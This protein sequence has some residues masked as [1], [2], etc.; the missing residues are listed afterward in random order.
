MII[1]I[2]SKLFRKIQEIKHYRV[3]GR[4]KLYPAYTINFR[5]FCFLGFYPMSFLIP[6]FFVEIFGFGFMFA[7][8]HHHWVIYLEFNNPFKKR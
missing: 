2:T 8:G 3:F 7:T 6:D 4:G 5:P 1:K